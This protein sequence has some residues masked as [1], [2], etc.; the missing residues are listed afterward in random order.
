M[1]GKKVCMS[2]CALC[3]CVHCKWFHGKTALK[4]SVNLNV[5]RKQKYNNN[6]RWIILMA[7]AVVAVAAVLVVCWKPGQLRFWIANSDIFER[8]FP[9]NSA[10]S[11]RFCYSHY[12]KTSSLSAFFH[13]LSFIREI[14]WFAHIFYFRYFCSGF[15]FVECLNRGGIHFFLC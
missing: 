6:C 5:N 1:V 10:V 9:G 2:L 12:G 8:S 15:D 13:Q 14:K 7:A 4:I 11:S 3:V